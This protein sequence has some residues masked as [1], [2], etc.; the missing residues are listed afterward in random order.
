MNQTI[1]IP[2]I[3]F[4]KKLLSIGVLS[5]LIFSAFL[6][7]VPQAFAAVGTSSTVSPNTATAKQSVDLTFTIT[8]TGSATDNAIKEVRIEVPANWDIITADK[9]QVSGMGG[10]PSVSIVG[11][12]PY[13]VVV[14]G[15]NLLGGT[16]GTVKL[17]GMMPSVGT[18]A[19][20]TSEFKVYW[21]DVKDNVGD[22][23]NNPAAAT[24]LDVSVTVAAGT[25]T[26]MDIGVEP[27]YTIATPTLITPD[28]LK[29]VVDSTRAATTTSAVT[30]IV[31]GKD[32][33]GK[34]IIGKATIASG[35]ASGA[36]APL[37]KL[38]GT[39]P[40]AGE[41]FYKQVT[42]VYIK[43]TAGT[44][45]DVYKVQDITTSSDVVTGIEAKDGTYTAAPAS[46]LIAGQSVNV[47][48]VVTDNTGVGVKDVSVSF[49]IPSVS[50]EVTGGSFS[51]TTVLTDASGVAATVYRTS[52]TQGTQTLRAT[53]PGLVGSGNTLKITTIWGPAVALKVTADP[54]SIPAVG[55]A[56]TITA[57]L[58]DAN[59]NVVKVAGTTITFSTSA[60]S[61]SATSANTGAD[62]KA[63]V[64]L[65]PTATTAAGTI[66]VVTAVGGGFTGSVQVSFIAGPPA[67][68]T[69]TAAA[70]SITIQSSTVLTATVKDANGNPLKDVIV[71]F[72]HTFTP[73]AGSSGYASRL[74]ASSATTGADG[75]ASVTL[76]ASIGSGTATITASAA[77]ITSTATAVTIKPGS[78]AKLV[79]TATAS[80]ILADGTS[81]TTITWKF[82]D[83][84]DNDITA[85]TDITLNLSTTGGT[86]SAATDTITTGSINSAGRNLKSS[87]TVGK[88]TVTAQALGLTGTVTVTFAGA[89]TDITLSSA[90]STVQIGTAATITVKL[91]DANGNDALNTYT[92]AV[93]LSISATSGSAPASASIAV[94]T[95]ST[96]FTW[97]APATVPPGG[98]ATI[99]VTA[100]FAGTGAVV[101]RQL[102]IPVSGAA[103]TMQLSAEPTTAP[104]DGTSIVK[105]KAWLVDERGV[106]IISSP[107]ITINFA[108]TGGTLLVSTATTST[109]TGIAQALLRAPTAPEDVT[110]T[111][112]GGGVSGTLV[113]KFTT[114]GPVYKETI[115]APTLVD[116]AGRT[117]TAPTVGKVVAVSAKITN[118]Q[119]VDQETL[120]I[121]QVKD[122]QGNVVSF[123]FVSG[124]IPANRELTFALSW[125]PT[126]KGTYTIEVF[127]WDNFTD[128]NVLAEMQTSTVTVG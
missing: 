35:S 57:A 71:T 112:S 83:A 122:A 62:G 40:G 55:G 31:V 69:L 67:S 116:T 23:V 120:Y 80:T 59:N 38:D 77:G 6:I 113:V 53:S 52:S 32:A 115:A 110:V 73:A 78:P 7:A 68:V 29:V 5:L 125:T 102:S 41:L 107:G 108:A 64:T 70:T 21:V 24:A 92:G 26:F 97:T 126:A 42:A 2:S 88:V 117:V 27:K 105:I 37:T 47:V 43:T 13:L 36:S 65:T 28:Q 124:L 46:S 127:A 61:L 72:V 30:V 8:H 95:G 123:S 79:G 19:S 56:S 76:I 63:S 101:T 34:G 44:P 58:I 86:L 91:I 119:N 104:A 15:V 98:I 118:T 51:A 20:Y 93:S 75:K 90:P 10:S 109:T 106:T 4:S 99:T 50:G 94:N 25:A 128:A 121:V 103:Y 60:G 1:N 39:A 81:T 45:G 33:A 12:T 66:A 87:T 82:R 89:G 84:Y 48:A 22:D 85:A 74:S 49:S 14:S 11:T 96:T 9:V 16:S 3:G 114:P 17:L 100:N 111:A 18:G 54:A